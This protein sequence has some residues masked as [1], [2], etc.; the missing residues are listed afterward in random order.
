MTYRVTMYYY[1]LRNTT[2]LDPLGELTVPPKALGGLGSRPMK[3][4]KWVKGK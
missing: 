3:K 1:N 2:H 4:R